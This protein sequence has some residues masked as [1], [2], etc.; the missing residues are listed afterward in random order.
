MMPPPICTSNV[1]CATVVRKSPSEAPYSQG[2]VDVTSGAAIIQVVSSTLQHASNSTWPPVT[3]TSI[4]LAGPK[5][6]FKNL[7]LGMIVCFNLCVL[8]LFHVGLNDFDEVLDFS[9][10]YNYDHTNTYHLGIRLGLFPHTL[11]ALEKVIK[12]I[13]VIFYWSA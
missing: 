10:R 9:R 4:V 6:S 12:K 3:S 8:C 11:D 7:P 2:L 1:E 13:V 5:N